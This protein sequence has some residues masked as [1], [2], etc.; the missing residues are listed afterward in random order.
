MGVCA[1]QAARLRALDADPRGDPM[2]GAGAIVMSLDCRPVRRG[3]G[4]LRRYRSAGP[5]HG[6]AGLDVAE[7]ALMVGWR[8]IWVRGR[9]SCRVPR[10]LLPIAVLVA[11]L[12]AAINQHA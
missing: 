5:A 2:A 4:L 9:S 6:P 3:A 7:A 11:G 12:A 10:W 8:L 1:A